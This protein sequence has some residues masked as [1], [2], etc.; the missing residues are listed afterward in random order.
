[1][2]PEDERELTVNAFLE[3]YGWPKQKPDDS[4]GFDMTTP[5]MF[6]ISAINGEG[7]RQLTLAIMAYLEVLRKEERAKR[8]ADALLAAQALEKKPVIQVIQP[9][10][11]VDE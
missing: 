8:D 7:T 5:R 6:A 10:S 2:L 4:D 1:M 9:V 11:G 3:A